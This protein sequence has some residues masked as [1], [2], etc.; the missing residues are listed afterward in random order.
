MIGGRQRYAI[1]GDGGR[2]DGPLMSF[3][4]VSSPQARLRMSGPL[5]VCM[6]LASESFSLALSSNVW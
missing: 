2:Y 1:G 5:C 4:P 6:W 3:G